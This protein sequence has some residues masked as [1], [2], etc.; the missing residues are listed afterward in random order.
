MEFLKEVK[1]QEP[2][3]VALDN[4]LN[5]LEVLKEAIKEV[6]NILR[7]KAEITEEANPSRAKSKEGRGCSNRCNSS[8]HGR[9]G[10]LGS[11]ISYLTQLLFKYK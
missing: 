7:E 6:E 1:L 11:H 5:V 2:R 4:Y 9:V 8:S 10:L 3:R